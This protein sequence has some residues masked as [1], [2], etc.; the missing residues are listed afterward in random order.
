MGVRRLGDEHPIW[1]IG[2]SLQ[3]TRA[4]TMRG[5]TQEQER[6]IGPLLQRV[7]PQSPPICWTLYAPAAISTRHSSLE[8]PPH[9]I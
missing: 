8:C 3:E 4:I 9:Q 5:S 2:S 1:V 6:L 7:V